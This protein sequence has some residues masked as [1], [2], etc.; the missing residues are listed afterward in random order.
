MRTKET[1]DQDQL[2]IINTFFS[3]GGVAYGDPLKKTS[4]FANEA[5]S[6]SNCVN[7]T[8]IT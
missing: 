3:N 1:P 6:A 4:G 5:P 7:S 2:Y 8:L